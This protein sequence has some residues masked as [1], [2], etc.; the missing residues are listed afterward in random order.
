M[1]RDPEGSQKNRFWGRVAKEQN[2][3][4]SKTKTIGQVFKKESQ[5]L[6]NKDNEKAAFL[7]S[8]RLVVLDT[9]VSTPRV[10]KKYGRFIKISL[11]SC[12]KPINKASSALPGQKALEG[13]HFC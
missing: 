1:V 4:K 7:C 2:H 3:I 5:K 8:T 10:Q 12:S 13:T 11:S 9:V 6:N